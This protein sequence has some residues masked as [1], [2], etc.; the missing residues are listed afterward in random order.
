MHRRKRLRSSA[1]R[2]GE[3]PAAVLATANG[4]HPVTAYGLST[5]SRGWLAVVRSINDRD[6]VNLD[7]VAWGHRRYPDHY[8]CWFV[9]SEQRYLGRFDDRHV[10]VAGSSASKS[11]TPLA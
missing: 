5:A 2:F 4:T 10:F 1:R 11:S 6:R 8:V 7:Q 3:G 9:I